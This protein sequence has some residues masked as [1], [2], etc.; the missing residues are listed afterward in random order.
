MFSSQIGEKI[1]KGIKYDGNKNYGNYINKEIHSSFIFMNIDEAVINKI[2][3]N[4][5]P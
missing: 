3:Y 5:P 2:I 1:S 4:L